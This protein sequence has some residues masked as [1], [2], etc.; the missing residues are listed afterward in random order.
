MEEKRVIEVILG[1]VFL[2]FLLFVILVVVQVP[3]KDNIKQENHFN[4]NQIHI[5]YHYNIEPAVSYPII[6]K[7]KTLKNHDTV[8][9]KSYPKS[10]YHTNHY[11]HTKEETIDTSPE[12]KKASKYN[13][14]SS[15]KKTSTLGLYTDTFVVNVNNLAGGQRYTVVWIFEDYWGEKR[16]YEDT[17]YIFGHD[18]QRF[19]FKDISKDSTYYYSWSYKVIPKIE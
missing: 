19:F 5:E 17:K 10:A 2:T 16:I 15:H 13:S 1:I 9:T 11:Q 7:S 6:Q 14:D 18:S 4:N 12:V 3:Y 8:M